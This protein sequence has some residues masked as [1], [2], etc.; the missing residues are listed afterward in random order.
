[1][2]ALIIDVELA[3]LRSDGRYLMAVRGA[4]EEHAAGL[5][6]FPGGGVDP[7]LVEDILE[8]TAIRE[9]AEE[10]GLV[11]GGLEY[12]ESHSFPLADGTPVVAVVFI[13]RYEGGEPCVMDSAEV[14]E[15]RWMT[16]EEITAC[17]ETPPW[18]LE[19]TAKVER[20]RAHLGW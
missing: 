4:G 1:V 2:Q 15:L 11:A 6:S 19:M 17:D 12:V 20:K 5:L 10:T 13:A 9:L 3:L 18:I 7:E 16:A 8:A 14:A